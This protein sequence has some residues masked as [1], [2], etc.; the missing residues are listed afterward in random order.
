MGITESRGR[1]GT[2]ISE[3]ASVN[4][5]EELADVVAEFARRIEILGVSAN[6]AIRQARQALG[7]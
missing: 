2:V 5:D 3:G 4:Q 1:H 6:E 7:T